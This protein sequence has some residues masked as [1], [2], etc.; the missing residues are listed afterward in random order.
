MTSTVLQ[1]YFLFSLAT[2]LLV[3]ANARARMHA[4]VA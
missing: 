2:L 1:F 4:S 3:G